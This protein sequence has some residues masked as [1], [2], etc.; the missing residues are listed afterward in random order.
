MIRAFKSKKQKLQIATTI[1]VLFSI[2]ISNNT[3]GQE[4]NR[5]SKNPSSI[6]RM[7]E[8]P[9]G[10]DALLDYITQNIHY[11][12]AA[13]RKGIQGKVIVTFLVNEEGDIEDIVVIKSVDPELNDEVIRMVKSMPKWKP[14]GLESTYDGKT[15]FSAIKVPRYP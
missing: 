12:E 15:R 8:F 1:V 4:K 7:H 3:F 2:F 14:G 11:S 10:Q 5:I 6:S 9:G 13:K